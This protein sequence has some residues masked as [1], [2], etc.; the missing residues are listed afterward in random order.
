MKIYLYIILAYFAA[1]SLVF[2]F[3]TPVFEGMDEN[4]HVQFINY[5]CKYKALPNPYEGRKDSTLYVGEGHQP[6]L[7][8]YLASGIN[9]LVNSGEPISVNS[10]INKDNTRNGG[11]QGRS[12][13]FF[14]NRDNIFNTVGSKN[15]FY[16]IRILS[17]LFGLI[18]II[19][20]FKTALL[21]YKK[22]VYSYIA[23]I[24]AAALPQ[25]AYFSGIIGNTSLFIL[26]S[27][28]A[29][30]YFIKIFKNPISTKDYFFCGVAIGLGILTSKISFFLFGFALVM[31]LYLSVTQKY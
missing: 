2:T 25:F 23:V 11:P 22:E 19:F 9:F 16:A 3:T 6:P 20:I 10:Q 29:F 13:V 30:Y 1:F 5:I 21:I 28:V 7:Y 15:S 17:I 27:T 24:F 14:N 4:Y 26:L 18:T 31:F 12:P 8:Y